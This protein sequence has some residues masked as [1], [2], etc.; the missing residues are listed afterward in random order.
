ML[1]AGRKTESNT[2]EGVLMGAVD[3][4][5]G[6]NMDLTNTSAEGTGIFG[7]NDGAQSF[8]FLSNGTGFIGKSG[9]GRIMFDGNASAIAS[10]NWFK[11]GKLIKGED[12][13]YYID[14]NSKAKEGMCINLAVYK[15][16]RDA[17]RA[18]EEEKR[19]DRERRE[20]ARKRLIE[21]QDMDIN[22]DKEEQL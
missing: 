14:P 21:Q 4:G 8:A 7:F 13:Y 10:A 3:Y 9:G 12:G 19:R 1:G 18:M 15:R 11:D 5:L 22:L 2:F 20:A 16:A 17:R 6:N